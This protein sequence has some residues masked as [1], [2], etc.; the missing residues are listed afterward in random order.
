VNTERLEQV[1]ARAFE[2]DVLVQPTCQLAL[3]L[4]QERIV[5][6]PVCDLVDTV[7]NERVEL[8]SSFGR[9]DRRL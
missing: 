4:H 9:W 5:E 2:N 3:V 1:S 6:L 7:S 8:N